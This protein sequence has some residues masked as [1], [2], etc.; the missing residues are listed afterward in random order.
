MMPIKR[1][2]TCFDVDYLNLSNFVYQQQKTAE[3]RNDALM[4]KALAKYGIEVMEGEE[5]T[6]EPSKEAKKEATVQ[7]CSDHNQTLKDYQD[8]IEA[9]KADPFPSMFVQEELR[10]VLKMPK[11]KKKAFEW[12]RTLTDKGG[13]HE[14]VISRL[15][16]IGGNKSKYIALRRK[17][18]IWGLKTNEKYMDTNR[19]LAIII[20]AMDS[21]FEAEE[22]LEC[23][24]AH[25][26]V[27]EVLKLDKSIDIEP[28]E[29]QE[30]PTKLASVLSMFF[31]VERGRIRTEIGAIWAY[32]VEK[33]DFS[34]FFEGQKPQDPSKTEASQLL[35]AGWD[36]F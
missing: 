18:L 13:T 6:E 4:S 23:S 9:I 7:V 5:L 30:R 26:R 15:E 25:N 11:G 2:P 33:L 8:T 21:R 36:V 28:F 32:N 12:Y 22:T 17:L 3:N 31:E 35:P 19:M 24:E 27:L 29:K 1:T 16:R 14:A 20:R 34:L 10:A